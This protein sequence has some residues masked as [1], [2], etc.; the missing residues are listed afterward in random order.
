MEPA[1]CRNFAVAGFIVA[2]GGRVMRALR[3]F[4]WLWALLVWGTA[5]AAQDLPQSA[6]GCATLIADRVDVG[7][8][9][10]LIATGNVEVLM[11][12]DRLKASQ[13]TFDESSETLSIE[14]PM[15]WEFADGRTVIIAESAELSQGLQNGLIRSARIVLDQQLQMTAA[16]AN[17]VDGRYTQLFKT[18]VS[19][20][21]VCEAN[22]TPLWAIRAR[23]V[24]HD[25]LKQRIYFRHA[26]FEILGI[27]ALYLPRLSFPD[28]TV[29]RAAGFL[30]PEIRSTDALGFGVKLPYFIP[31]GD[32][33]DLT[34]TPYFAVD[35]TRTLE[36]RYRHAFRTG[37]IELN[38]AVTRDDIRSETTRGYLFAQGSFALPRNFRLTFDIE[39]TSD[40]GYL[41]D[42]DYSGKDRLDSALTVSRTDRDVH[43]E[44]GTIGY[45]T[46]RDDETN[47]T[48][49][50]NITDVTW[51]KRFR[52]AGIGGQAALTFAAHSHYRRSDSDVDGTDADSFVDG[53]DIGRLTASLDWRRDWITTQG[54]V[55]AALADLSYVHTSV[56]DDAAFTNGAVTTFTGQSGVELRWPLVKSTPAASFVLE[57]VVQVLWSGESNTTLPNDESTLLELDEGNLFS[58]NRFPGGDQFEQGVRANLGLSWTRYDPDGWSLGVT[59]GRIIREKDLGQFVGYD[60]LDGE[61]SHW[62][63]AIHFDLP[64]KLGI[65]NR[66]LFDDDFGFDR[67]ELRMTYNADRLYLAGSLNWLGSNVAENRPTDTSEISLDGRYTINQNW[68]TTWEYRYDFVQDR[69]ASA[70]LGVKYRNECI[71]VGVSLS[72][73]FTTSSSVLP[74]TDFGFTV[75]LVGF[76]STETAAPKRKKRCAL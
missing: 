62:L 75:G 8:N 71:S 20:C 38:M 22:P 4:I 48:Q 52:P 31:I 32:H 13:I 72:R 27:P 14:G 15:V 43:F 61:N 19:S 54:I 74:T 42:Y 76:G 40:K 36:A 44:A 26:R 70:E 10:L 7:A 21:H 73:R 11:D 53:R 66:A 34:L 57:P 65:M 17:R 45:R 9:N 68:G 55:I 47:A 2:S 67:N 51:R 59:V 12:G 56:R 46:L 69:A 39:T 60:A 23:S 18:V 35:V 5:A 3:V 28:A 1:D 58:F 25:T 30:T 50:T 33:A 64:G 24:V 63:A 6:P 41:L 49:P 16:E 29:D 37:N